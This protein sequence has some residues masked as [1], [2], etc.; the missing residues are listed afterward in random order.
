M[1]VCAYVEISKAGFYFT[2]NIVQMVGFLSA[3]VF[4]GK[5]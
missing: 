3:C 5:E 4:S 2:G 1:Y